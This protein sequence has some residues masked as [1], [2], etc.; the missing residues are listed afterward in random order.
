M[1]QNLVKNIKKIVPIFLQAA[2]EEFDTESIALRIEKIPHVHSTHHVHLWSL[3]DRH[4]IFSA[5]LVVDCNLTTC[6]YGEVKTVN[7]IKDRETGRSRG[8]AFVEMK[9]GQAAQRAIDG[10]NLKEIAGR[11]VTVNEARPREDRRG[12][13]GR[14]W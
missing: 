2:P 10:L 4:T 9:D 12:G 5:H 8:F 7:I 1:W 11:A 6:E 3:D 13:G 14:R